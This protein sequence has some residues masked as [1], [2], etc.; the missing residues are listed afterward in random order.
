MESAKTEIVMTGGG[1]V[2][3]LLPPQPVSVVTE[4]NPRNIR[5]TEVAR[6]MVPPHGS[7][8]A[9]TQDDESLKEVQR[10][11]NAQRT[12]WADRA[13]FPLQQGKRQTRKGT[14]TTCKPAV[15]EGKEEQD[16]LRG[17]ILHRV[18]LLVKAN[19]DD[20]WARPVQSVRDSRDGGSCYGEH[21]PIPEATLESYARK[22]T[23]Q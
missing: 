23:N 19:M 2:I 6:L 7:M 17:G 1:G 15:T 3:E 5:K 9:M 13:T 18:A 10:L 14:P 22:R 16:E 21:R 8:F 12:C 4:V 20:G 11:Q